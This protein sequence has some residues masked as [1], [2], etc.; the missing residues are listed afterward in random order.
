MKA[1]VLLAVLAM[2]WMALG[3]SALAQSLTLSRDPFEIVKARLLSLPPY[4][5]DGTDS[6]SI[7]KFTHVTFTDG[8][9]ETTAV[10]DYY[11]KGKKWTASQT[12]KLP[13]AKVNVDVLK[14]FKCMP[15]QRAGDKKRPCLQLKVKDQEITTGS[16]WLPDGAPSSTDRFWYLIYVDDMKT[17]SL[18]GGELRRLAESSKNLGSLPLASGV[19]SGGARR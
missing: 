11:I 7:R 3:G 14:D 10:V 19:G 15:N 16:R 18:L 1:R 9:L 12:A 8:F 4:R 13:M 5:M 17:A 2:V 6:Y